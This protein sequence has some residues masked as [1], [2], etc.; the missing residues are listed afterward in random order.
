[1]LRLV[2]VTTS[3]TIY[4]HK[5]CYRVKDFYTKVD[6]KLQITNNFYYSVNSFVLLQNI[7][8][9]GRGLKDALTRFAFG[10][11]LSPQCVSP[12]AIVSTTVDA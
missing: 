11:L 6:K 10:K 9:V 12:K 2:S 4:C 7:T 8:R 5:Q 1:M 3:Y